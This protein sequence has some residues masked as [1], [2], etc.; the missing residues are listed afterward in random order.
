MAHGLFLRDR[1]TGNHTFTNC[2]SSGHCGARTCGHT[3]ADAHANTRCDTC[4]NRCTYARRYTSPDCDANTNDN[5][6]CDGHTNSH[7]IT[8]CGDHTN[9]HGNACPNRCSHASTDAS[10]HN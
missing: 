1:Y 8:V 4:P 6:D 10:T 2:C 3:S 7:G 9:S 5:T